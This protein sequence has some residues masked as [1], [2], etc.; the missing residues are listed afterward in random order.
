MKAY[1]PHTSPE[2]NLPPTPLHLTS[3][4][5]HEDRLGKTR[6]GVRPNLHM[7]TR[8]LGGR[9]CKALERKDD[10]SEVCL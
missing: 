3:A 6:A 2:K 7:P 5:D 8:G 4:Q 1:R 10:V 9:V